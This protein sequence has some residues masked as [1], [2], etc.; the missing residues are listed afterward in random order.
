MNY[1]R[2]AQLRDA[3]A[4]L[5]LATADFQAA[6]TSATTAALQAARQRVRDATTCHY[7]IARALHNGIHCDGVC[8]LPSG[9]IPA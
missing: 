8:M 7:C 2:F 1:R 6:Q 5:M 9:E 3:A 4:A